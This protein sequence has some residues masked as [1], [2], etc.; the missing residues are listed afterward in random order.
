M[1][2]NRPA[3]RLVYYLVLNPRRDNEEFLPFVFD[4]EKELSDL[5]AEGYF[6]NGEKPA[7]DLAAAQSIAIAQRKQEKHAELWNP[8]GLTVWANFTGLY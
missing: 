8:D 5:Q 7:A 4:F 1:I 3:Y 6:R 2:A